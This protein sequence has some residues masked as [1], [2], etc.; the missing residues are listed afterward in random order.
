MRRD[1]TVS[2]LCCALLAPMTAPMTA[3]IQVP[4]PEIAWCSMGQGLPH[5]GL[6]L[7]ER[8]ASI[9][10]A[11][12]PSH[13]RVHEAIPARWQDVIC[14]AGVPGRGMW[15]F[16]ASPRGA[17]ERAPLV[18]V[19]IDTV[20]AS[21]QARLGAL[22]LPIAELAEAIA[23]GSVLWVRG[24]VALGTAARV[25]A[26]LAERGRHDVSVAVQG[27]DIGA[28]RSVDAL[29]QLPIG[30]STRD[31]A[32]IASALASV[33]ALSSA[34]PPIL[35]TAET[36]E[37]AGHVHWAGMSVN[38]ERGHE[39]AELD[40]VDWDVLQAIV[41]RSE[42]AS[43]TNSA[44]EMARA[45]EG[46]RYLASLDLVEAAPVAERCGSDLQGLAKAVIHALP[47]DAIP[48]HVAVWNPSPAATGLSLSIQLWRAVQVERPISISAWESPA[49]TSGS[50]P[51]AV[52]FVGDPYEAARGAELLV[53]ASHGEGAPVVDLP[54]L[55]GRMQRARVL[56]VGPFH[57]P[58]DWLE[59][60]F[61]M[62]RLDGSPALYP[63]GVW[64]V[65]S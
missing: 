59:E 36:A 32:R 43:G 55:R 45:C 52:Q 53:I 23:P 51:D 20:C 46:R 65:R 62:I 5:R 14:A 25:S 7:A 18:I 54:K 50:V 33:F 48:R 3:T 60:G 61:S 29:W 41:A 11:L 19:E 9:S 17:L 12:W 40:G 39:R 22:A 30:A 8:G 24:A 64:G 13:R 6:A 38:S 58:H 10:M 16:V 57:R 34:P 35:T 63:F 27:A 26:L 37:L 49:P 1:R 21:G 56:D 44:L 47:N 2:T 15:R 28:E 42:G 31:A 4:T